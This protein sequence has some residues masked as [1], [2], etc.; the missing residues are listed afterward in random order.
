MSYAQAADMEA[1]YPARDLIQLTNEVTPLQLTFAGS[2]GTIQL[3]F[4]PLSL[5][6]VQNQL[7]Q[8]PLAAAT[9]VENTDYSVNRSTGV[10]TRIAL[11]SITAGATVYVS[12]DNPTFLQTFLSDASNEIDAYLESRFSLPLTDPPAILTR[13]CCEMAMWHLQS[14]RPIHDLE[15]AK[16]KYEAC[17]KMLED[18]RDRALT[19][20]LAVDGQEPA[21]PTSPAVV[22]DVNF[23]GDPCLPQRIFS[24]GSLKGF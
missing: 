23:G 7:T 5:V 17:I 6:F 14:L 9:Y 8:L 11:G 18:V 10:I 16:T 22:V 1:R 13:M 19:L 3:P 12:A 21:D 20:G 2:P 24:R 4:A 15:D